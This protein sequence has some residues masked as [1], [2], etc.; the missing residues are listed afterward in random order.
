[1]ALVILP[2]LALLLAGMAGY[3]LGRRQARPGD[4]TPRVASAAR[5]WR[6]E[7]PAGTQRG[8]VEQ[9]GD[10]DTLQPGAPVDSQGSPD[11]GTAPPL[12]PSRFRDFHISASSWE[13][14]HPPALAADGDPYTFWHAWKTEKFAEGDWLTLTF[15][16]ERVVTR[17][18]LLPGRV[19]PGAR[20]EGR[21]RSLLVKAP[22]APPQKLLFADQPAL[23]YRDLARPLRARTLILRFLTVLPGRESRHLLVPEVQVWGRPAATHVV[24]RR[25]P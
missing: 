5:G 3:E 16:T 10:A 18:G 19:G 7:A 22:G 6:G 25:E 11:Q 2:I 1:V 17:I 9:P 20:D 13:L 24:S 12:H 14:A 4:G 8:S 15:P 21:V 23:Q